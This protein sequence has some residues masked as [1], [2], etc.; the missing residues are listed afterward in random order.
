MMSMIRTA[1]P[2]QPGRVAR[3][4]AVRAAAPLALRR[5]LA[6]AGA[7][8]VAPLA[9]VLGNPLGAQ[10][11]PPA[12]PRASVAAHLGTAYPVGSLRDEATSG[13]RLAASVAVRIT[14]SVGLYAG[15]ANT[16]LLTRRDDTDLSDRGPSAGFVLALPVALRGPRPV[17]R[18]GALYNRLRGEPAGPA[19]VVGTGARTLGLEGQLGWP[20]RLGRR[21]TWT[22]AL[23]A[24]SYRPA[25]GAR[26]TVF[27]LDAGFAYGI[28]A[29]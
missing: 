25:A 13:L 8:V 5:A 3:P 27:G 9:A 23:R 14:S 1:R 19:A 2:C 6:A 17:A 21:V 7:L 15:I 10:P 11:A 24:Q 22:P 12:L 16:G 26:A 18:V 4:A 28:A 29:R 20:V